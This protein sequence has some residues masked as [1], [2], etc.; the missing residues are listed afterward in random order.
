MEDQQLVQKDESEESFDDGTE[1]DN[2]S[3][4]PN[5]EANIPI[6]V[7]QLDRNTRSKGN[8]F[9]FSR[10]NYAL[11]VEPTTINEALQDKNSEY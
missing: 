3:D 5:F 11:F 1:S 8:M 6:H 10:A 2:E 7:E 4:D 9:S